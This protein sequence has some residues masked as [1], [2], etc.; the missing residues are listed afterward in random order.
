MPET[1]LNTVPAPDA[2]VVLELELMEVAEVPVET[3]A[4]LVATEAAE[5]EITETEVVATVAVLLLV[6]HPIV[7]FASKLS[8]KKL[9]Y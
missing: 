5:P 9:Y 4:E 2:T 6:A 1:T 8:H 3:A 7:V